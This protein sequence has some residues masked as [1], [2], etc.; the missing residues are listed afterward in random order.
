M[1]RFVPLVLGL[2][3]WVLYLGWEVWSYLHWYRN[4][5]LQVNEKDENKICTEPGLGGCK[6][7]MHLLDGHYRSNGDKILSL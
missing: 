2:V 6:S 3:I 7:C 5:T 1:G 4:D